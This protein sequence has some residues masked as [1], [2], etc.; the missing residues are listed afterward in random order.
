MS[1]SS[2]AKIIYR[3]V[4]KIWIRYLWNHMGTIWF[5]IF[6][7]CFQEP[8]KKHFVLKNTSGV[9]CCE[10]LQKFEDGGGR[11]LLKVH[12]VTSQKAVFFITTSARTSDLSSI[13]CH[14]EDFFFI[15]RAWQELKVTTVLHQSYPA[16]HILNAVR[17]TV[18]YTAEQHKTYFKYTHDLLV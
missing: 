4:N 16:L 7:S 11:V 6:V 3:I 17:K 8:R 13:M 18:R 2:N 5:T 1:K 12:G 15:S 10:V 9:W 14:S